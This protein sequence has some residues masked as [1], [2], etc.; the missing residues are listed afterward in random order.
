MTPLWG[1]IEQ[2]AIDLA[3]TVKDAKRGP[4]ESR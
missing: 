3:P 2:G 1:L 4:R